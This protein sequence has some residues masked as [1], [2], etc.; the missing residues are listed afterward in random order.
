MEGSRAAVEDR[1]QPLGH[2]TVDLGEDLGVVVDNLYHLAAA[3]SPATLAG[4]NCH[5][6]DL[7]RAGEAVPPLVV[8]AAPVDSSCDHLDHLVEGTGFAGVPALQPS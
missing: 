1:V 3:R 7:L 4:S 2:G 6:L 8:D 5:D